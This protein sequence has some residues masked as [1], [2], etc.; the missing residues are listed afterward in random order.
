MFHG[1]HIPVRARPGVV[2]SA[3]L[4][5]PALH[6]L[7]VRG[8]PL[9]PTRTRMCGRCGRKSKRRY[10]KRLAM[11]HAS[12]PMPRWGGDR[13]DPSVKRTFRPHWVGRPPL[14]HD[15]LPKP[16]HGIMALSSALGI[17][18]SCERAVQP[19]GQTTNRPVDRRSLRLIP[20]PA[21]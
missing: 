6:R 4:P 17:G 2:G 18:I 3:P 19:D 20:S 21:K 1:V 16:K 5:S 14:R 12:N 13:R 8:A 11:T 7:F 10:E 15:V 9:L